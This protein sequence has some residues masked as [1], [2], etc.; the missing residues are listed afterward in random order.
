MERERS[1]GEQ[2]AREV[3]AMMRAVPLW[4][5]ALMAEHARLRSQLR[6]VIDADDQHEEAV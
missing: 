1:G 5:A 4:Q 6:D 3:A 2:R